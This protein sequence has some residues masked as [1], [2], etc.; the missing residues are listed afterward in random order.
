MR[1]CGDWIAC[2]LHPADFG[3]LKRRYRREPGVAVHHRDGH[4]ALGFV[5]P[6]GKRGLVF[7]DPPYEQKDEAQRLAE[8]LACANGQ[9]AS[10]WPG[11]Q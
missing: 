11:I 9:A 10:S 4:E 2:E 7:I 3:A 1:R 6:P 5:P 8:A